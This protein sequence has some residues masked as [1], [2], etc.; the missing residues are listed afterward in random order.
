MLVLMNK[1]FLKEIL[2]K[3]NSYFNRKKYSVVREKLD[4][5]KR[6]KDLP[7]IVII[8][9]LRRVGKSTLLKQINDYFYN[10]Q[11][12]R[13][14]NFED[15]KLLDFDVKE[16]NKLYE[17]FLE[18]NENSK[19]FLFDEIQNLE[20]WEIA[21][22]RLYEE[23]L[24]FY[25]TW[26]NSKLLSKELWTKLTGRYVKVELF[27]FSFKEFLDFKWMKFE[28][29]DI[30][31]S[32]VKAKILKNFNK[33]LEIGWMPEYVKYENEEILKQVYDDIIYKDIIVRYKISDVKTFKELAKYLISN[34]W[35]P[36]SYTKLKNM[37][38]LWSVNTIKAYIEYL[39]NSYLIYELQKYDY[40]VRKQLVNHKKIYSID[41][42]FVNLLWFN[43]SENI[44]RNL[45]NLVFIELK[46]RWK[47]LYYHKNKKECDFVIV[48]WLKPVEVIQVTYSLEGE[49]TR[50]K[51]IDWILEAMKD[52]GLKEW[53]ILTYDEEDEIVP[54]DGL[55]I[56]VLPIWRWMMEK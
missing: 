14:L 26:S 9:G 27:P 29:N 41:L 22:R 25:I 37:L 1:N 15:E 44:G 51:E 52:Y 17:V 33:Y 23:W 13:Y 46:R 5:V 47:Q 39:Q 28:K 3:Q 4:L 19:V 21:I 53:L 38:W 42:W 34:I 18:L 54:G 48:E 36:I 30:Y 8:S 20:K 32:E 12:Y 45:E 6:Y 10:S 40:S 16:F 50:K 24:K 7:H 43:F 35:K 55:K 56:K 11:K 2:V 31:L 49:E